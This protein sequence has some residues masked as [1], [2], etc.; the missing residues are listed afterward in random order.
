MLTIS[1][2]KVV[3]LTYELSEDSKKDEVIEKVDADQPATF[4]FGVGGLLPEFEENLFGLKQGDSFKFSIASENAY[5]PL[6]P[7]ALVDI[8]KE[9]FTIDGKLQED[10]LQ[11]GS[12]LPMR[13]NEDN[14]LQ[15]RIVELKDDAVIMDFNHPLA[16]KDLYFK[17]T[18]I[19]VREATAEEISHGHV[20]GEGGHHH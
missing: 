7:N 17:G 5:G 14:F 13:D 12:I 10:M 19:D 4:L 18:I 16:G 1:E 3:R 15:G 11:V 9:A 2:N 8:P 6:D 20:H